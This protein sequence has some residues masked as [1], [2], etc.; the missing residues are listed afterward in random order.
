MIQKLQKCNKICANLCIFVTLNCGYTID[1]FCVEDSNLRHS[2]FFMIQKYLQE[3][4]VLVEKSCTNLENLYTK[5]FHIRT[6]MHPC[7][8]LLYITSKAINNLHILANRLFD[9]F[10][11]KKW[12]SIHYR[13]CLRRLLY[14][15]NVVKKVPCLHE[16]AIEIFQW[17]QP[18]KN[19]NQTKYNL[20]IFKTKKK[21][22]HM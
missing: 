3:D 19:S 17:S 7:L 22:C 18:P 1:P 11:R 8:I 9:L 20:K 10:T 12:K 5:P 21:D 2:R 13:T 4:Y 15:I 6:Q 16:N 14:V